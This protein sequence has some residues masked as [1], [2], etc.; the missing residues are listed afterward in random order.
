MIWVGKNV[1]PY[2]LVHVF[3]VDTVEAI[4]SRK[5]NKE[6]KRTMEVF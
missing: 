4:D 5:V 6:K 1:S 2:F 3:G